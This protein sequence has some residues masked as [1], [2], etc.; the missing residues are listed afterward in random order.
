MF[1]LDSARYKSNRFGR[2]N[3][4]GATHGNLDSE[5]SGYKG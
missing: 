1:I 4:K 3:Y 2:K 5:L